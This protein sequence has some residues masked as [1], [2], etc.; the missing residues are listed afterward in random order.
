[1][2][3]VILAGVTPKEY[4]HDLL[5]DHTDTVHQ[6]HKKGELVF[7]GKHT[8][9]FFLGF[10]FA[11]FIVTEKQFLSFKEIAHYFDYNAP[12]YTHHY[13]FTYEVDALRG[14]PD[15]RIG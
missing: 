11:P 8:H 12:H 13:S 14:P 2:L 6:E 9:C 7:S 15:R 4:L 10:V 1:M 5:Y 3:V